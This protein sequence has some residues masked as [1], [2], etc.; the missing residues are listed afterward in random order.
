[1]FDEEEND[2]DDGL[3]DA[4]FHSELERFEQMLSE[5]TV[6]YFDAEVLEQIIEHFIINNQLKKGLKA[7]NF[8]KKQHPSNSVFDL[9]KAQ[10]LSTSGQL[11]ERLLILQEIEKSEPY[12]PE[13]YITKASVFS[14]LRDH[15]NAIKYFEKAIELSEEFGYQEELEEIR[16]DLAM[17]YESILNFQK[18][19]KVFEEILAKNEQNE[20]A[21]YEVAY[22]YERTGNFDKC[23]EYYTKYIDN[24]PY[25]FTAWY[26]LGNI[27]FL[28]ENIEKAIWAY[29]YSIIINEDFASAHFNLGNIF[30]QTQAY[31]KA[32]EAYLKCAEIDGN[33]GLT[34][35]YLG[36]AYERLERYDEAMECYQK[37]KDLNPE[38]AEPWLGIGIIL[39]LQGDVKQ[40][41]NFLHQAVQLQPE[42]ANYRLVYGETLFKNERAIEAESELERAVQLDPEYSEAIVLLAKIKASYSIAEAFDFLFSLEKLEELDNEVRIMLSIMYWQLGQ[43]TESIL[44]FKKELLEDSEAAKTLFL[45]F[46]EAEQIPEFLQII[47][48]NNE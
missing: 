37:S 33:D 17:E 22:C 6:V 16:F 35:S 8:G 13:V 26:N 3:F 44:L 32:L 39:E 12:N 24:N 2:E 41:L 23:I 19:I 46:P 7:V 1:M 47:A 4:R 36:E 48:T 5:K 42:N 25:S 31:D 21:I 10:I 28:K 45:Y 18:A 15:S 14:Q 9:R 34:L 27:Y 29:D 30:M 43:K 11:K 20:A 40:S 38:L